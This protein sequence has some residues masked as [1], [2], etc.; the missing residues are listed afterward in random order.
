MTAFEVGKKI[1]E[2]SRAGK[3]E[4]IINSFFHPEI[5]S[6]EAAEMPGTGRSI[7]GIEKI[8]EK[9]AWWNSNFE[10][11]EHEAIGPFPSGDKERV[12]IVFRSK[13]KNKETGKPENMEEIAIYKILDGKIHEEEFFYPTES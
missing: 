8:K 3:D 1:V 9:H 2:L 12:A 6:I 11:I 10:V 13:I 7:Q 5:V 4:E